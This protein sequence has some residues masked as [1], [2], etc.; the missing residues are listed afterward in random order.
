MKQQIETESHLEVQDRPGLS[1]RSVSE[2]MYQEA[3]K[4]AWE[5]H[6]YSALNKA[7]DIRIANYGDMHGITFRVVTKSTIIT[8]V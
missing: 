1:F 4:L 6:L 3:K 2:G 8:T 5:G 7:M